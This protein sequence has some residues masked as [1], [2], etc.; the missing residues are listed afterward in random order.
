MINQSHSFSLYHYT[1]VQPITQSVASPSPPPEMI[2]LNLKD[3][4][5]V[6]LLRNKPVLPKVSHKSSLNDH[7]GTA[8][9]VK[10]DPLNLHRN[11][12]TES[13]LQNGSLS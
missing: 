13:G 5:Q 9:S 12:R 4:Q 3:P 10:F 11:P 8:F 1:Q 2:T 6:K 7:S